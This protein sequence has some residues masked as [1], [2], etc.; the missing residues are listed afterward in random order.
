MGILLRDLRLGVRPA[1]V[2]AVCLSAFD[3]VAFGAAAA[4]LL[5]IAGVA[6]LVA[7]LSAMRVDPVCSLRTE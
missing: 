3:P 1:G 4:V 6:N 7:A 5:A 2:D